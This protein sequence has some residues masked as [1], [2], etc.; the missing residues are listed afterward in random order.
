MHPVESPIF[1]TLA[2]QH[3]ADGGEVEEGEAIGEIEAMKTFYRISAPISGK[4][5]WVMELGE[6]IGQGDI[7]AEI[8][9]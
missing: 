8:E 4:L 1:G 5:T 2:L 3:V 7:I 6:V 9:E